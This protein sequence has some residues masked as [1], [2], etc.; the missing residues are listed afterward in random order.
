MRG[1]ATQS[2]A[3]ALVTIILANSGGLK[4]TADSLSGPHLFLQLTLTDIHGQQV[5]QH[6]DNKINTQT[7]RHPCW[8]MK[9][10][11]CVRCSSMADRAWSCCLRASGALLS[12][13]PHHA[14]PRP[15]HLCFAQCSMSS[16]CKG[17][18]KTC[19]TS[20]HDSVDV[21]LSASATS[22]AGAK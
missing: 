20:L 18:S 12:D 15:Y 11:G 10:K 16:T 2:G 22:S 1:S 9:R 3:R 5:Q 4:T 7:L 13:A 8:P 19:A 6:Q 21:L 17:T 14:Q